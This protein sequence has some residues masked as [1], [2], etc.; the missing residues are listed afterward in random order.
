MGATLLVLALAG[1][2]AACL[3]LT[4]ASATV[5]GSVVTD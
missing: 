3:L 2:N 4:R 5:G 1:S